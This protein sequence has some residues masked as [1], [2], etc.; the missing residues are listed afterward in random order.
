[1]KHLIL[2]GFVFFNLISWSAIEDSLKTNLDSLKTDSIKEP[3][4]IEKYKEM[5]AIIDSS[6]YQS[7]KEYYGRSSAD[8]IIKALGYKESDVPEFSD[9]VYKMRIQNIDAL[10]PFQL[11]WNDEVISVVK[12]FAR[13][14]RTFTALAL[15]RSKLYFPMYEE[16]LD[17]Y[18]LPLELKYLS[19]I[20]SGLRPTIK[21]RA[22]AV[23]LW[24]FMY[25]TGKAFGLTENSYIDERMDPLKATDAA[26]RYLK[27]LYNMYNDWSMALAAYNAGPGNVNKAIRRSG[28]KTTYWEIREYLPRETQGYVPGF[29][30]MTYMM[31]YHAEHNIKPREARVYH[32]EVDTVCLKAALRFK[33]LDTLLNVKIDDLQHLNPQF[34]KDYV[35][36]S[37]D[38]S[39][40]IVLPKEFIPKFIEMEDSIYKFDSLVIK[41]YV[42]THPEEVNARSEE[43]QYHYVRSGEN[44]GVIAQKYGVSV[45]NLMNWN[46]LKST[47][48]NIGQ[49]LIIYGK[50]ATVV[51]KTTPAK[52]EENKTAP[53]KTSPPPSDYKPKAGTPDY[54]TLKSGESL[55]TVSQ[56]YGIPFDV[57]QKLNPNIDPKKMQPGDRIKLK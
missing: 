51:K 40:C 35:P 41:Q 3:E 2:I 46:N 17:K 44:L 32:Y 48:I 14:R 55:W 54:H 18:D 24:Q 31:T 37:H 34:K 23:G 38:E 47:R 27:F 36:H 30:A 8:S 52:A 43:T 57:L 22:G 45:S 7:Y 13:K 33:T 50:K 19:I 6:I 10:T 28:G 15:G 26:C 12:Y 5:L 11:G 56:K 4:G 42:E 1:M 9:S 53:V 16:M 25:R 29:I 21:S 49:K 20:E 39:W